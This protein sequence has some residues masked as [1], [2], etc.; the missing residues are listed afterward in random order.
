MRYLK[1]IFRQQQTTAET[2]WTTKA[3]FP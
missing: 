3:N 1:F 2:A